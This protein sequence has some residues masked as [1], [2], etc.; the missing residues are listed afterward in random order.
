MT[1]T[2]A[3]LSY[4]VVNPWSEIDPVP[5]RG[6]EV[7]RPI[8]LEGM[9]IGLYYMWKRASKPILEA[10]ERKLKAKYPAA[11]FLWYPESEI[12]TPEIESRNRGK[13]EDWLKG[14]DAVI[15]TFGD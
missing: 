5:A 1:V 10:L 9:R 12:N 4:D 3:S 2:K 14:V 8:T 7:E 13:Y 6:L 11:G 15:F